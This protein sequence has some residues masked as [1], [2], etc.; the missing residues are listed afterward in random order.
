MI[1]YT[2]E[3]PLADGRAE[4]GPRSLP[5]RRNEHRR[6]R[7]LT[8][9]HLLRITRTASRTEVA[10]L[11]LPPNL[12]RASSAGVQ[13][14]QKL[15]PVNLL[16]RPLVLLPSSQLPLAKRQPQI[17]RPPPRSKCP[18]DGRYLE[19]VPLWSRNLKEAFPRRKACRHLLKK[20]RVARRVKVIRSR[21]LDGEL[22][23]LRASIWSQRPASDLQSPHPTLEAGTATVQDG[24]S[25]HRPLLLKR[26][27]LD[28]GNLS[29]PHETTR[30][31]ELVD[32]KDLQ[33]SRSRR[34]MMNGAKPLPPVQQLRTR[35]LLVGSQRHL[36]RTALAPVGRR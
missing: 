17:K 4:A 22:L 15:P 32:G 29:W 2:P 26:N 31:G 13:S 1:P 9:S 6:L 27:N 18:A 19:P 10:R 21:A 14:P 34:S 24:E 16:S 33:T 36:R 11:H 7:A 23:P 20:L 12:L 25:G 3:M 5:S 30:T 8:G 28:R 35:N